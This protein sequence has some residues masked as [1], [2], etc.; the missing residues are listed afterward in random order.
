MKGKKFNWDD[1][2]KDST[3]IISKSILKGNNEITTLKTLYTALETT[4]QKKSKEIPTY[5]TYRQKMHKILH[6]K[7]NQKNVKNELYQLAGKYEKMT[8]DV[9]AENICLSSKAAAN[10]CNWLFIR[11][12]RHDSDFINTQKHLYY[13]SQELKKKFTQ[14]IIFISFDTDTIVVMCSGSNAKNMIFSYLNKRS[15]CSAIDAAEGN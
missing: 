4:Y 11:L 5:S 7:H 12:K 14:E 9:L 3:K 6:I 2:V 8:L 13:L 15:K 10:D 1:I